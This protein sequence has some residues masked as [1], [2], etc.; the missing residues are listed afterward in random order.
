MQIDCICAILLHVL[1][2]SVKQENLPFT[3][4]ERLDTV[5]DSD[6]D[7]EMASNTNGL[8]TIL[9]NYARIDVEKNNNLD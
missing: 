8:D 9:G 2:T 1:C 5:N 4:K 3:T 7:Y 6:K